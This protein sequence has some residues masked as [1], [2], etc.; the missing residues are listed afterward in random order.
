M[1]AA[2]CVRSL[3]QLLEPRKWVKGSQNTTTVHGKKPAR[4]DRGLCHTAQ[5]ECRIYY[6]DWPPNSSDLNPLGAL[7]VSY[8]ADV[9]ALETSWGRLCHG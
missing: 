5:P 4:G 3:Q 7:L 2:S 1:N 6:M 9:K 8:N